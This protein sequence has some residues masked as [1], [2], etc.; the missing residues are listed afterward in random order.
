VLNFSEDDVLKGFFEVGDDVEDNMHF[1]ISQK[2]K[3][4]VVITNDLKGYTKF[5]IIAV[6]PNNTNY[7]KSLLKINY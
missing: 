5:D 2:R 4:N 7:L 3:C 6:A 1:V